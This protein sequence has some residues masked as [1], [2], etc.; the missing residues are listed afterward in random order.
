MVSDNRT[1]LNYLLAEQGG[2]C[3]IAMTS[4]CT[5][6]NN[7]GIKETQIQEIKKKKKLLGLKNKADASSG[8]LFDLLDTN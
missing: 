3:A 1:V 5:W 2:I 4:W 7:S 8:A 6:V